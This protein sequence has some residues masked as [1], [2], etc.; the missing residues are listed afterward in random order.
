MLDE[1]CGLLVELEA[2]SHYALAYPM[3]INNQLHGI[4]ALEVSAT[5]EIELQQAMEQLQW[6]ASWLELLVLRQQAEE[7]KAKLHRLKTAV[8]LLAVTHSKESFSSAAMAFTTEL[9]AATGCERVSLG[10]KHNKHIV[11]KAVSHSSEIGKKM[12]LTRIIE[13][14][15]EEA[16]LQR[17]EIVYPPIT[18]EMFICREH[19]NLSRQQSMA[20]IATFP[21][22]INDCYTGALTCE[23]SADQPFLER[24]IEFIRAV[25]VLA[26][27]ALENKYAN[28]RSLLTKIKL[29]G[30]QQLERLFGAGHIGRKLL[31]LTMACLIVF[32]S[33]ATGNYRVTADAF[34]EGSIRRVIVVPFDGYIYQAPVRAGDFVEKGDLLCSLDDR[35][36][37]LEKLTKQSQHKQLSRQ[38]QEAIALHN[39]AQAGII[40]AQMEQSQAELDLLDIFLERTLMIAPFAG[41][42]VSGDLSQR[43]GGAVEQG[44]VL[45]EVTPLHAYRVI[46][47]VDERQIADVQTGQHGLL[48]LS[49]LPQ[50]KYPFIIDKI[51][52]IAQAEEGQN[53]SLVEASLQHV[54]AILRPGMKGVGKIMIDRHRL[55]AIW[56]R[57]LT[58]WWQLFLWRWLP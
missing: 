9:A 42:V 4:V 40:K 39:R 38:L 7:N 36:L 17:H 50:A 31:V 15:M 52:P 6:G 58:E 35:D 20:S 29:A 34:L 48:I 24:D 41:L 8:D 27:P 57:S 53:F 45:F 14:V 44:E 55:I 16:I 2:S 18:E 1:H 30:G 47:K 49:A 12:N 37:R 23:R 54:D 26:G 3:L 51:T 32:F 10:F 19:E 46:L 56:T 22:Y 11:L 13:L 33:L 21:L 25:A 28:D 5:T 43:L